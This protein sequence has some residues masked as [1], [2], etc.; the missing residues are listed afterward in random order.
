MV[1][2]EE[3][4]NRA[5]AIIARQNRPTE[6]DTK[7]VSNKITI[8]TEQVRYC[9]MGEDY[10][11]ELLTKIVKSKDN[12][13]FS[14]LVQQVLKQNPRRIHIV[15][16]VLKKSAPKSGKAKHIIWDLMQKLDD[17]FSFEKRLES[18]KLVL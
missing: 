12:R 10:F 14:Y 4:Q 17:P 18:L 8:E 6:V 5:A 11:M 9:V 2:F 15:M 16:A 7:I 1:S 13:N 3:L